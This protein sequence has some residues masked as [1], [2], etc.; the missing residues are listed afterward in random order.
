[1]TEVSTLRR[2]KAAN[3]LYGYTPELMAIDHERL[4]RTVKAQALTAIA[5]REAMESGNPAAAIAKLEKQI[6]G[7]GLPPSEHGAFFS[8]VTR[9]VTAMSAIR[10]ENL[11]NLRRD[12]EVIRN[13]IA[14]GGKYDDAVVDS[15]AATFRQNR[16]FG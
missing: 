15:M 3:P 7:L 2:Q 1:M 9:D 16:A 8:Q 13:Q 6:A 10:A 5:R 14:S 4:N 12:A 11:V